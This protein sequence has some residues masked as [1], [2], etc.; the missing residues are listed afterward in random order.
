MT[1]TS[2][3]A[4]KE[5]KN[6]HKLTRVMSTK[7]SIEDDDFLQHITAL[8]YQD[9]SIKEPSKSELVRLCV[10]LSLSVIRKAFLKIMQFLSLHADNRMSD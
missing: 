8:A 4:A 1:E 5:N 2:S 6:T 7:L 9:G 3:I 10:T